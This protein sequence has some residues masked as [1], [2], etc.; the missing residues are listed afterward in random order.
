MLARGTPFALSAK[1]GAVAGIMKLTKEI[2]ANGEEVFVGDII[3]FPR[4]C[5]PN[6]EIIHALLDV[7]VHELNVCII[8]APTLLEIYILML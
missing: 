7:F 8:A 2:G 5:A 4:I 1:D 6:L 3:L